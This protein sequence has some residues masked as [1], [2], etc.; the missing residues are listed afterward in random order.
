MLTNNI[1]IQRIK[2]E[3]IPGLPFETVSWS[4]HRMDGAMEKMASLCDE[5]KAV[6]DLGSP[7]VVQVSDTFNELR[8]TLSPPEIQ[9]YR[10]LGQEA[11][12]A[13]EAVCRDFEPGDTELH[14]AAA[15]AYR[16]RK[17]NILPLVDW[18]LETIR[19]FVTWTGLMRLPGGL[20]DD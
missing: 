7:G 6:S 3:E 2:D 1:E 20:R 17:L 15:L 11:A 19:S 12:E 10:R 8:Y 14:I 9:R 13:V 5:S 16:C 18:S 4:W